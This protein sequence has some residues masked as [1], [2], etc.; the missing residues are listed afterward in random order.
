MYARLGATANTRDADEIVDALCT[1]FGEVMEEQVAI[2][3][4]KL[5]RA[6]RD[7]RPESGLIIT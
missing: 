1:A 5:A 2:A 4:K 7:A 6:H 3:A